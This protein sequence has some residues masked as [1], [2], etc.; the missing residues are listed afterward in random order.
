ME[1]MAA[2]R[3]GEREE[4]REGREGKKRKDSDVPLACGGSFHHHTLTI[5]FPPSL[6]PALPLILTGFTSL[7][8]P[9]GQ[10]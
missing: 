9:N 2:T 8:F 1:T 7:W 3:E 4:G 10:W 5:A 6:P